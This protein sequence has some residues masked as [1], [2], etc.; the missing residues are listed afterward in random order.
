M[1][2]GT[3]DLTQYLLAVDRTNAALAERQD[4]AHPAVLRAIAR[5]VEAARSSSRE[6]EV[7]V[8]GE[9]AGD[10]TGAVLLV[11][12]GVDELSMGPA[13]FGSVKRAVGA[14][15]L[16]EL[17]SLAL[18]AMALGSSAAVRVLVAHG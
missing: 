4:A 9:M 3:N 14:R 18:H 11:G 12:L 1:S 17:Q 6:C 15:S 2:I 7:A 13:S 16:E 10:P 8:C 5:V